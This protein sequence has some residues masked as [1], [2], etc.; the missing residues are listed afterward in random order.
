LALGGVGL[1]GCDPSAQGNALG[2]GGNTGTAS[3]G[4]RTES[5]DRGTKSCRGSSC[6]QR[7]GRAGYHSVIPEVLP[8]EVRALL[9]AEG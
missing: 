3:C 7:R 9:E 1:K 6:C 4:D 8:E 2:A 5:W